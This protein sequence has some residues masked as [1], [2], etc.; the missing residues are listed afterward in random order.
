MPIQYPVTARLSSNQSSYFNPAIESR[1]R[2]DPLWSGGPQQL[3]DP[4]NEQLASTA[5]FGIGVAGLLSA[6][7]LR[8][9]KGFVWERFYVPFLRRMEEYSP[10]RMF[11][12]FRAA[13]YTESFYSIL[14]RDRESW[15]G[16]T[17]KL[18]WN[19]ARDYSAMLMDR[20]NRL[21]RGIPGPA[22]S[23]WLQKRG[24]PEWLTHMGVKKGRALPTFAR[25]TG[26]W[27]AVI[28]GLYFGYGTLDHYLDQWLGK[29]PTDL[30]ADLY[31]GT[32]KAV[33]RVSEVT[34]LREYAL[35]QEE[36][37]PGS[38]DIQ[39]LVAFPI[40]GA[41]GG[42]TIN[43]F[44]RVTDIMVQ[45]RKGINLKRASDIAESGMKNFGTR[46]PEW[47]NKL[48]KMM[49]D[50]R[51]F[52][53]FVKSPR[54]LTVALGVIAGA[55][56]IAPFV[57]GALIPTTS[58]RELEDI[59]TGRQL[60][61]IRKGRWWEF[62]RTP[63]EGGKIQFY[64]PHAIALARTRARELNIYGELMSPIEKFIKANFTYEFER[65][66]YETRPYPITGAAF[67]DVPFIGPLL[68]GTI[69]RLV[70]PPRLMHTEDWLRGG[71]GGTETIDDVLGGF[72]TGGLGE[73]LYKQMPL[74]FG[75]YRAFGLGEI[76]PGGPVNPNDPRFIFSEQWYR[77]TEM[78]GLPGFLFEAT[79]EAITGEGQWFTQEQR[80]ESARRSYGAERTF[81]DLELGGGAFIGEVV[82]RLF[83]H[84]QRAI[85]LYNPIRNEM[86]TWLPGPGARAPDFR[87][88]DPFT[89]VRM[90][91]VRLPGRGYAAFYPEL[92]DVAPEDYPLIHRYKILADIAPYSEEFKYYQ[93]LVRKKKKENRL[94]SEQIEIYKTVQLQ[95]RARRK[96]KEFDEYRYESADSLADYNE[97]LARKGSEPIGAF[98]QFIGRYWELLAHKAETPFEYLTPVSPAAKLIHMRDAIED[99]ERTQLYGT[100]NAFWQHPVEHFFKPFGRAFAQSLGWEGIPEDIQE[101]REVEEYF[102]LL[103]YVKFKRLK[104]MAAAEGDWEASKEFESKSRETR[105]GIN[106]Y[107]FDFTHIYRSLPKRDRDYFESFA[108]ETDPKD[109]EKILKMVPE[110]ARGLYMARWKRA[111]QEQLN[112]QLRSD[113][114]EGE[115]RE[116]VE[117]ELRK[118][119]SDVRNEGLPRSKNLWKEYLADHLPGESYA[120]WYRRT[121]LLAKEFE[122]RALPGPDWV[123]WHPGVDLNDIKLKLVDNMGRDM[124][125]FDL[126]PSDAQR[127]AH[128]PFINNQTIEEIDPSNILTYREVQARIYQLLNQEGIEDVHVSVS[129]YPSNEPEYN[130]NMG[131]EQDRSNEIRKAFFSGE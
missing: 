14:T 86:P 89:K 77:M 22:I 121:K 74:S 108:E 71:P 127:L 72:G 91:E 123:G 31:T 69:G 83:P 63:W 116:N 95:L 102:D 104:R 59:Y 76:S 21:S 106:P 85:P 54:A 114:L 43:Y 67:E 64:R 10:G 35:R 17:H 33:A 26:K 28:A 6:G 112:K 7:L 30:A 79:K 32:R 119:Q 50:S 23:E 122:H 9:R 125:D 113:K 45:R 109:R 24:I 120:D 13:D 36:I 53:R 34:G 93:G 55:A 107:T 96:R 80:L 124:H 111:R 3:V 52:G 129:M 65:K 61:G 49:G 105:F 58:A 16:K 18:L 4:Y 66:N 60:V 98:G 110:N 73:A 11:R 47:F 100:A 78:L 51:I 8:T 12:T 101:V 118:I 46:H 42:M 128:K 99:Y 62:G 90:G 37:A 40:M 81:W 2:T 88:G 29:G 87:H 130:I 103:K 20:F 115:A 97:K 68:A 131:I 41:A 117:A 84:R 57:P 126:W 70:K 25:I 39:R 38:T 15:Q 82:R 5:K 44:R 27:T 1:R 94:D 75:G 19:K 56:L 48:G 92:E